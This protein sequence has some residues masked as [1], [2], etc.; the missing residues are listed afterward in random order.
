MYWESFCWSDTSLCCFIVWIWIVIIIFLKFVAVGGFG[1]WSCRKKA[2]LF[3]ARDLNCDGEGEE[4]AAEWW[5]WPQV[6]V[7]LYA[8]V[9]ALR[10]PLGI[11]QIPSS[12]SSSSSSHS[13]YHVSI[14][15]LHHTSMNPLCIFVSLWFL[16][17]MGSRVVC[18]P[19]KFMCT[20]DQPIFIHDVFP[21]P[22]L[23][24]NWKDC[25]ILYLFW[26]LGFTHLQLRRWVPG[27]QHYIETDFLLLLDLDHDRL[28]L[29]FVGNLHKACDGK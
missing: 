12:S 18:F 13:T 17:L 4:E 27:L 5:R 6:V 19:F 10:N 2:E 26:T 15:S 8:E 20:Y 7:L 14:S 28:F 23:K 24:L 21:W 25:I 11:Q 9:Q 29:I 3:E 1:G 16:G 22:K